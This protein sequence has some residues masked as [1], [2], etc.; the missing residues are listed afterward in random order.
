MSLERKLGARGGFT[1]VELVIVIAIIALLSGIVI[2]V[3]ASQVDDA[4]RTRALEDM[5]T[6]ARAFSSFR[7]HTSRWPSSGS[8]VPAVQDTTSGNDEFL[9]FR[10]LYANGQNLLGWKG[11]YLND[12]VMVGNDMQA[13]IAATHDAPGGGLV[14]PWG[15]PYR[16]YR[17]A[18][19]AG[20]GGMIA[21][22]CRGADGQ[23]NSS[24]NDV[25][26]GAPAGDDILKI[27]SRR[28]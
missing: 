19:T 12:G 2:P 25:S 1:L 15:Q 18:Q 14:D 7:T 16:V 27:I 9:G 24:A 26:A 11:P 23:F 17:F 8:Q 6:I 5:D 13:A 4:K 3:V 10:C 20:N 22:L 28:L 21:L